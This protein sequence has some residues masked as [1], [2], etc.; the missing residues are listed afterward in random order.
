[1]DTIVILAAASILCVLLIVLLR[2][3]GAWKRLAVNGLGGLAAFGVVNLT[4]LATGISLVPNLWTIGS[5]VLLGIPGI[6]GLMF[7]KLILHV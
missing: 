3:T 6:V 5:A 7:V 2:N 4:G 1:M